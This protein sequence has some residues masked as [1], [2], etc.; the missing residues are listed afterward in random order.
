MELRVFHTNDYSTLIGWIDSDRLNYQ[1]GEPNY[2]FP[3]DH[4]QISKHCAQP[5]VYPFI[6]VVDD[7][8]AGYVELYR[9]SS[10]HFRICRVFVSNSFRGRG[11][12][13]LMLQQLIDFAISSL[14]AQEIS[15]AVFEHNHVAR[16][17][18]ESLGFV[19]IAYEQGTRTFDGEVWNL[20]RMSKTI[21]NRNKEVQ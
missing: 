7:K 12:A 14:N 4:E 11:V 5:Q 20:L 17:C 16:R 21:N 19:V 3:L 9:A 18:Y 6:F 15:L 13:K 10:L 8:R 1:W 2:R